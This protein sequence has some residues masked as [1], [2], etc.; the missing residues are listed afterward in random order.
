M[1]RPALGVT[2]QLRSFVLAALSL[3]PFGA[4]AELECGY[5]M[6]TRQTAM[7]LAQAGWPF[8]DVLNETL[9]H[10][11]YRNITPQERELVIRVVQE[12]YASP[13]DQV[14]PLVL[15]YCQ[16][17]IERKDAGKSAKPAPAQGDPPAAKQ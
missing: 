17:E 14:S 11:N 12:A 5:L 7:R 15:N 9:N 2:R 8:P 4:A 10:P 1:N 3:A 13:G 6:G 16:A